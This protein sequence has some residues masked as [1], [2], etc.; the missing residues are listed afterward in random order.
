[1][2]QEHIISLQISNF[3]FKYQHFLDRSF[4]NSYMKGI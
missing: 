4:P 1:M 2:K 3:P